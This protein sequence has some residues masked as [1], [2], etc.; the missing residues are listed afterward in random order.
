[1]IFFKEIYY[2]T[3]LAKNGQKY[4]LRNLLDFF[5]QKGKQQHI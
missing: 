2:S 1:M 4:P 5:W 3:V